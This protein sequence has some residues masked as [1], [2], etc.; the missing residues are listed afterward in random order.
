MFH[1]LSAIAA[2]A[3]APFVS[4]L[5]ASGIRQAGKRC[6]RFISAT[7]CQANSSF[8]HRHIQRDPAQCQVNH[9]YTWTGST[10]IL[11]SGSSCYSSQRLIFVRHRCVPML[12][13]VLAQGNRWLSSCFDLVIEA[14]TIETQRFRSFHLVTDGTPRKAVP[15]IS[16][17]LRSSFLLLTI[18]IPTT[19]TC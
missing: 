14:T 5:F 6:H 11:D 7:T 9:Q 8:L 10:L 2:A 1:V 15:T 16:S 13:S 19:I 18:A 17:F 4:F 12:T 3:A